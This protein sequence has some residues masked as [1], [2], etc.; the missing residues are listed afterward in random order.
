M[1][2]RTRSP[3]PIPKEALAYFI[4]KGIKPGFRYTDVWREKHNIAFTIAKMMEV[5]IL[6]TVQESLAKALEDGI[7]FE[8]WRKDIK[9]MFDRSGWTEYNP[10]RAELHRMKVI[11]Q[12]NM[13]SARSVGQWDRI[14]R[15]KKTQ[16]YLQYNLGPSKRH[17]PVH[18][19]WAGLVLPAD[20]PF[21]DEAYPPNGYGCKCW[22]LQMSKR[23]ADSAGG[24]SRAPPRVTEPWK[25]PK[26]GEVEF[27]R[28]GIQPG[29]DH[30]PGKGRK[31]AIKDQVAQS[32]AKNRETKREL[33]RKL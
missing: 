21:W 20:H 26:T 22:I 33:K 9:P 19:T 27:V 3:G 2:P 11:Y 1:P 4:A 30:N 10:E 7:P 29:F 13:R 32:N 12:T 23:R 6:T 25:N 24:V 28:K 18:V 16:P 5:D 8:E 17:R 31:K 14:Q 15:T